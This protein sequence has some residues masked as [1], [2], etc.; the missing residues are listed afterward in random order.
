M[1]IRDSIVRAVHRGIIPSFLGR[2]LAN[3][4]KQVQLYSYLQKEIRNAQ[5]QRPALP[6]S[7]EN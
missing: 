1:D 6:A 2:L 7:G 3:T 4:C 5:Q